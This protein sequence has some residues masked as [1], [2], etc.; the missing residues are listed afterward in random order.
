MVVAVARRAR[1]V[2]AVA[3]MGPRVAWAS[4]CCPLGQNVLLDSVLSYNNM[5]VKIDSVLSRHCF[6]YFVICYKA[7][8]VLLVLYLNMWYCI[9]GTGEQ[10]PWYLY[11]SPKEV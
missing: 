8:D 7:L 10:S 4:F 3:R 5:R 11:L 9:Q 6:F 2:M 1:R